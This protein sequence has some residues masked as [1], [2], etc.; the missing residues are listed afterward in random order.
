LPL[1]ERQEKGQRKEKRGKW[2]EENQDQVL[3]AACCGKAKGRGKRKG[4][5]GK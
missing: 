5:R 2:K 4:E 3:C 1:S